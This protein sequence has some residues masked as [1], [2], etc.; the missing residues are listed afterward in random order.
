MFRVI[1]VPQRAGRQIQQPPRRRGSP[2]SRSSNP[3]SLTTTAAATRSWFDPRREGGMDQMRQMKQKQR[4]NSGPNGE[5]FIIIIMI[6]WKKF[7]RRKARRCAKETEKESQPLSA[8][9]VVSSTACGVR[10][11]AEGHRL[12]A[13]ER[14]ESRKAR[15]EVAYWP[16]NTSEA[17]GG[18]R[19]RGWLRS[20]SRGSRWR[21]EKP[22]TR[23]RSA[24]GFRQTD[25]K[26][27]RFFICRWLI[28][29]HS[30]S[31]SFSPLV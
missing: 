15:R 21:A 16:G 29:K 4:G 19:R 7:S 14:G 9:C 11:E 13:V 23:R 30:L 28:Y 1:S 3:K 8:G 5:F 12:T 26:R 22:T 27:W 18:L 6:D 24:W 17:R 2:S 10:V 31:N 20:S 25:W